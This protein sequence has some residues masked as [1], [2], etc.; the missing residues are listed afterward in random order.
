ML[1]WTFMGRTRV[2][3][4]MNQACP[5]DKLP[6]DFPF[7]ESGNSG[8]SSGHMIWDQATPDNACVF[9]LAV[10]SALGISE[11]LQHMLPRLFHTE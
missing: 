8:L 10:S 2:L 1:G 4:G 7:F 6:L 5:W 11:A 9:L 3:V